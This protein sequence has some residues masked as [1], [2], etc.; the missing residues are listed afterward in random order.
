MEA[1]ENQTERTVL[2][3]TVKDRNLDFQDLRD[4]VA[5]SLKMGV[6]VLDAGITLHLETFPE[7]GGVQVQRPEVLRGEK[8]EIPGTDGRK[9]RDKLREA[10]EKTAIA[11]RLREYRKVNG[12]G[13]FGEL[14]MKC[15]GGGITADTLRDAVN[16]AAVLPL[17][18]WR[19][20]GK[21]L[22]KLGEKT[23]D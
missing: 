15:G 23:E 19:R 8:P 16:G 7:L 9:S 4:Y 18:S 20:I 5:N 12:L 3:V 10:A 6:L 22:D 21:A 14:A 17:A 11:E 1:A 2:V 13:C